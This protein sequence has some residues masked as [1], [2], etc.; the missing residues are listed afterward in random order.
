MAPL[1]QRCLQLPICFDL[2][3]ALSPLFA[4]SL[5]RSLPLSRTALLPANQH[6]LGE[7]AMGFLFLYVWYVWVKAT[8]GTRQLDCKLLNHRYDTVR[9]IRRGVYIMREHWV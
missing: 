4:H 5:T 1:P 6:N 8:P 7:C 9:A 3:L 2:F